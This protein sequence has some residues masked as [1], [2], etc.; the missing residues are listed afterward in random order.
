MKLSIIQTKEQV[1]KL[2]DICGLIR[3]KKIYLYT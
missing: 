1:S 3:F 2:I